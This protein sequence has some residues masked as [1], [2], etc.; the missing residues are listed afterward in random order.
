MSHAIRLVV[1]DL[2]GTILKPDSTISSRVQ[3]AI[4]RTIQRGTAVT[5]ATGRV[6]PITLKF[7]QPLG[8]TT[9]LICGN[10]A[11]IKDPTT[12]QRLFYRPVPLADVAD[13]IDLADRYGLH[14]N[15]YQDDYVYTARRTPGLD[16]YETVGPTDVRIVGDLK[17][18]IKSDVTKM[19]FICD[20]ESQATIEAEFRKVIPPRL[21]VIRSHHHFLEVVSADATKGAAL[22]FLCNYLN[23]LPQNVL[24]IGDHEND[25]DLLTVAGIGV[26]MASGYEKAKQAAEWIAPGIDAD[27][28][29]VAIE[30]YLPL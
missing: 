27:G 22:T 11:I 8:I 7:A 17:Q 3:Q 26:A 18:F 29:A 1:L 10:G 4:R 13:L 15:V 6:F 30:K 28:A 5:L 12:R 21:K 19:L 14:V 9:P 25:A 20:A 24:A 16:L 23:I 2:D